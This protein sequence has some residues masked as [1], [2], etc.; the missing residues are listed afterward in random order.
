MAAVYPPVTVGRCPEVWVLNRH[1][2]GDVLGLLGGARTCSHEPAHPGEVWEPREG[3]A[4]D[5]SSPE[6]LPS[7]GRNAVL[8]TSAGV[9]LECPFL[10][11][12]PSPRLGPHL[13]LSR[14][15]WTQLSFRLVLDLFLLEELRNVGTFLLV[16]RLLRMHVSLGRSCSGGRSALMT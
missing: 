8:L 4:V 13:S 10:Q 3:P 12:Q 2:P 16:L 15:G 14:R 9:S 1:L 11:G 5:A 6:P 7:L